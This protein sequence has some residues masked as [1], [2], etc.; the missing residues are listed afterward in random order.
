MVCIANGIPDRYMFKDWEHTTEYNDHIRFLPIIKEGNNTI[1]TATGQDHHR[2]NG[3][4]ICRASNNVSSADGMF[5]MR[6]YTL[7]LNGE[8]IF[9][10]F[11]YGKERMN[12]NN[13]NVFVVK[14]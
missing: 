13:N 2:D 9:H 5:V 3:I 12:Y 4:Y 8:S 11:N 1:L 6:K 7:S 10:M 14:T